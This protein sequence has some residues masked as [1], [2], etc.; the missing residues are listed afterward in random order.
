MS[1][2]PNAKKKSGASLSSYLVGLCLLWLTGCVAPLKTEPPQAECPAP[3]P[4]ECPVC[5]EPEV[6]PEPSVVEKVVTK[7]VIKKVPVAPTPPPTGAKPVLPTIGAVEWVTVEPSNLRLEARI[8]TGAEISAIS[9]ENIELVEIDGK[10]YVRYTLRD[11]KTKKEFREETRLRKRVLIKHADEESE[12]RYVVR[13]W[14]NLGK[15]RARIDVSLSDRNDLEYP[16]LI[17]RNLLTD[18][19]IVDVSRHHTLAH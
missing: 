11:P 14:V 6:C 9:A 5:P 4:M 8:D 1:Q 13:M 19:V 10:R 3:E 17:G 15:T 12:R 7:T 16:M 2:L 18:A